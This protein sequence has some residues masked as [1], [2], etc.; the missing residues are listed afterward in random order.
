MGDLV[1]IPAV[2]LGVVH[3][4]VGV[5]EETLADGVRVFVEHSDADAGAQSRVVV[6]FTDDQRP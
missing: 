6:A 5:S 2:V 3:R 1:A 4:H